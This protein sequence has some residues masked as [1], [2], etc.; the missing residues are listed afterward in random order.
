MAGS[1]GE[2]AA[3]RRVSSARVR[4]AAELE[5]STALDSMSRA[6]AASDSGRARGERL[7]DLLH[8]FVRILRCA[9]S[10]PGRGCAV[11]SLC[12]AH[13]RFARQANVQNCRGN[14]DR[15][16]TQ[17]ETSSGKRGQQPVVLERCS[18]I[19]GKI[20]GV[21]RLR[22]I[23][24]CAQKT[25]LGQPAHICFEAQRLRNHPVAQPP[26]ELMSGEGTGSAA[27]ISHVARRGSC[28]C[29]TPATSRG[30]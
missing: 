1:F 26:V 25:S 16:R 28:P 12:L 6:A 20:N 17:S 2:P 14:H 22:G 13:R 4:L 24:C 11:S 18:H 8:P 19:Q 7:H 10:E 3:A 27:R 15:D 29:A 21:A 23:R 30:T 9:R 5:K